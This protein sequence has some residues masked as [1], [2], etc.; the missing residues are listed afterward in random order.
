MA[1]LAGQLT[2]ADMAGFRMIVLFPRTISTQH[3][4]GVLVR[5]GFLFVVTFLGEDVISIQT[6]G[7]GWV[8]VA[9]VASIDFTA[10]RESAFV[11]SL[12]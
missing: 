1:C 6:V 5:V 11:V 9:Y 12:K 3:A 4:I 8:V 7:F 10:T 2:S